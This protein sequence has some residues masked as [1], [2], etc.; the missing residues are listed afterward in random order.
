MFGSDSVMSKACDENFGRLCC[1]STHSLLQTLQHFVCMQRLPIASPHKS[2][3]FGLVVEVHGM[4]YAVIVTPSDEEPVS[5]LLDPLARHA[6]PPCGLG[7]Q[8]MRIGR[9]RAESVVP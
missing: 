8:R 6:R 5:A 1:C 7:G 2:V 4:L 3:G 9:S